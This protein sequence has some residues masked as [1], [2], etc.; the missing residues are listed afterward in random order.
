MLMTVIFSPYAS[1]GFADCFILQITLPI[2]RWKRERK[3]HKN[4]QKNMNTVLKS[5]FSSESSGGCSRC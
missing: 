2:E 1:I 3:I 4:K 5:G